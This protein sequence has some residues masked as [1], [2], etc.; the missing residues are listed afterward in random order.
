MA[1]SDDTHGV[2]LL[3]KF[4]GRVKKRKPI[5][6]F[7]VQIELEGDSHVYQLSLDG[8]DWVLERGDDV[9]FACLPYDDGIYRCFA[10]RNQSRG[11]VYLPSRL[12]MWNSFLFLLIVSPFILAAAFITLMNFGDAIK[13]LSH[14]HSGEAI[15]YFVFMAIT[16][17]FFIFVLRWIRVPWNQ[18]VFVNACRKVLG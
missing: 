15:M 10:Y 13:G 8:V 11:V 6:R 16:G 7:V 14:H 18:R 5:T 17:G 1:S 12:G 4:T 3:K 2:G 9:E